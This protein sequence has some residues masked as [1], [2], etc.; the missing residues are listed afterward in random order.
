MNMP[1]QEW[2]KNT[3]GGLSSGEMQTRNEILKGTYQGDDAQQVLDAKLLRTKVQQI[4]IGVA[5]YPYYFTF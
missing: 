3:G 2:R 1:N 5:A 4:N